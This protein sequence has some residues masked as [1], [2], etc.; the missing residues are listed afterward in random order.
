MI[1]ETLYVLTKMA[2]I[3][4]LWRASMACL[5]LIIAKHNLQATLGFIFILTI[6]ASAP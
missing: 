2:Y 4:A 5:D 3:V 6:Y 1:I